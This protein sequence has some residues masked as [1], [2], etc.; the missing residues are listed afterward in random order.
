[1][2]VSN[3]FTLVSPINE[4]SEFSLKSNKQDRDINKKG[5]VVKNVQNQPEKI[6]IIFSI[7][8]KFSLILNFF[9]FKTDV[10][11]VV[12]KVKKK[13]SSNSWLSF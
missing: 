11:E 6:Q 10:L 1:M 9:F 13:V 8:I 3:A 5:L 4:V 2:K 12:P 7:H